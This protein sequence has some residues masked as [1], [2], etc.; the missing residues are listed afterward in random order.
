MTAYSHHD[1][2]YRFIVPIR[3]LLLG[4]IAIFGYLYYCYKFG[5]PNLG[6][7]D[8]YSYQEMVKYPFD[9]NATPAPFVLRQVPTFIAHLFYKF[10]IFYDTRTNLDLIPATIETKRIFFALILSN[11]LAAAV[12]FA[13]AL[14]YIRRKT[15][16]NDILVCFSYFGI[17]LSYFYLPFSFIAPLSYGWGWL[18][19]AILAIALLERMLLPALLGCLLALVTRET[20]LIFVL[21][22]S[23]FAWASFARMDRFFMW[24]AI[25][26]ATLS[27][28]LVLA[29]TYIVH[30]YE[31]EMNIQNLI[32]NITLFRPT[33]EFVFWTAIPQTLIAVLVISLSSTHIRYA[34]ALGLSLITVMVVSIG[35][36]VSPTGRV[37]GETLPFY[38]IIFLLAKLRAL[39]PPRSEIAREV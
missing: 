35:T 19:S 37:L 20:I 24:T 11:A 17:M 25:M 15:L 26:A 29:R 38:A 2:L 18:T 32:T 23:I 5:S 1:F 39:T 8:F 13:I 22:F 6:N 9:L 16:S 28:A 7:N 3:D 30:G 36:G 31:G 27:A 21:A 33:R 4:F 14:T 34:L 10:G 12:S